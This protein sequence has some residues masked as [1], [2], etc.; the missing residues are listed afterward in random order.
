MSKGK[1]VGACSCLKVQAL[2]VCVTPHSLLRP[3]QPQSK[4]K[5]KR[6][7]TSFSIDCTVPVE[8]EI[9]EVAPLVSQSVHLNAYW[10]SETVRACVHC[11]V[12]IILCSL[13]HP[14]LLCTGR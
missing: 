5:A 10:D 8:D 2:C 7:D 11:A 9:M 13:A 12:S 14:G 1:K 3:L 4:G 6:V